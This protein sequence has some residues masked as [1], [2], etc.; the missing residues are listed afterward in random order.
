MGSRIATVAAGV[1][2]LGTT[3]GLAWAVAPT[4]P[5]SG[6]VTAPVHS[7][8]S[9]YSSTSTAVSAFPVTAVSAPT[10]P[11]I[12]VLS[13]R[14]DLVSGGEV[15]VAVALPTGT[16]PTAVRMSLDGNDV[17]SEFALRD[18]GQ[19]EGLLDGLVVGD[20]TLTA[21]MPDGTT[22][23]TTI[24]DHALGGPLFAGPQ[25]QP[26][27]CTNGSTDAQ[28]NA[29][30]VYGYEYKSSVTGQFSTYDPSKPPSDVATTT[31]QNG[32][33]VP[34]VI[35]LETGYEDRDQYQ[36]AVL[37]QP[38]ELW[39]A[40]DPQPQF[41]HKLLI[42]HGASCGDDH[43]SSTAPS[44]TSDTAG[45][46][47]GPGAG[48]SP[49]TALGM[50][51]AVMSTAL[52]N[53]GHNCD[54]VTEAESLV[55]AKQHLIDHYGTLA[56]TIG[57]GCSGGSLVQQQVANAY[58]GIYQGILPQCSFPDA[59][60]TGQQLADYQLTRDYFENPQGWGTG[61]V[62]TPAQIA[63]VQG[64]PNYANSVELS[65]LYWPTLANPA[66]ACAGV[67]ASQRWSPSNPAG[68][69]CDLEDYMINVF[70][71]YQGTNPYGYAGIPLDNVGVEYGLSAL[72][73]GLITP[74]QFAD[75]NAKIGGFDNNFDRTTARFAAQEPALA[76]DYRSGAVDETNNLT[77]VAIID[78]RG[79]DVGSF[80]DAY[81]SWTIRARL[82]AQEGH[83]PR[84]DVMWFGETPLIGD[85]NYT[86]QAL[87]AMDSWL[88]AVANDGRT[89]PLA[90]KIAEDRPASVHDQCSDI[91][92]VDQVA[93]PGVGPVCELPL[94][95]TKFA[96]PRMVAGEGI[97]TD[98]EK[99]QLKQ[100]TTGDFYPLTF[101]KAELSE[102]AQAFPDGVCDFTQ[103]GVDQTNTI[104]WLTYQSDAAGSGVVYG[105]TPLGPAP[106]GSGLGWAAPA[107]DGWL[108]P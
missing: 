6:Q 77:D 107:F 104:P 59:W 15:L 4:S 5:G 100:L 20:N 27:S 61:V 34:F 68:T 52:D 14:S 39:T 3:A 37:F 45:I 49:T 23:S 51:Y 32:T 90:D 50:G 93:V 87:V 48:S 17:T 80:H 31:T 108:N 44:T 25:V 85:P 9:S 35:R 70:G 78:L 40:W 11:G 60:S 53:A 95:Q 18:N 19:Y 83:F 36:I 86:S 8:L 69:R 64:H 29:P 56:F 94:L 46:P 92:G 54:L 73:Q 16:D 10:T 22:T 2:A 75:L 82:E 33:K 84:N 24:V 72:Q 89:V 106:A 88:S 21:T 41:V 30:V 66:Y 103:P 43:Q 99:C 65:T 38:G 62:W 58:P 67:S 28:C 13:T 98:Q 55:M 42:T 26:W 74:A 81:R 102:L 57:T 79:P 47:G 105:G 71:P 101:S 1:V 76:N 97:A 7:P 96:T 63:A 12:E 91:P